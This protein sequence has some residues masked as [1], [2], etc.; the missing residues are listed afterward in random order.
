M[1]QLVPTDSILYGFLT[2]ITGENQSTL[3]W[4]EDDILVTMATRAEE[5][6]SVASDPEQAAMNGT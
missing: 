1:I 5:P 6:H 3:Q 4:V 2:R